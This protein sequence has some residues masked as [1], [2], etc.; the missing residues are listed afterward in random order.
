MRLQCR[1]APACEIAPDEITVVATS[2]IITSH[3]TEILLAYIIE[4]IHSTLNATIFK[5]GRKLYPCKTPMCKH[6]RKN[7][8]KSQVKYACP[9]QSVWIPSAQIHVLVLVGPG[10]CVCVWWKGEGRERGRTHS[11]KFWHTFSSPQGTVVRWDEIEPAPNSSVF[12][13]KI[14]WSERAST[15]LSHLW[16]NI[17][18]TSHEL[19]VYFLFCV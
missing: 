11:Q 10:K 1:V 2:N 13:R 14:V 9:P 7:N 16:W 5:E 3:N 8:L 4:Q 12:D 15:V 17:F 19:R 18:R 6:T